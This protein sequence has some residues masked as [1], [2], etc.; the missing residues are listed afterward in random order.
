MLG[1]VEKVFTIFS[2]STNPA[3][4][5]AKKSDFFPSLRFVKK[6]KKKVS[7]LVYKLEEGKE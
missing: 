6:K 2:F 3:T 4:P 5:Q 1:V 7:Y